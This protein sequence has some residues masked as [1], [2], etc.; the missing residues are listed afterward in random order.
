[1]KL[2]LEPSRSPQNQLN[3]DSIATRKNLQTASQILIVA[4][5]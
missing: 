3:H 2:S 4:R 5:I 1:M